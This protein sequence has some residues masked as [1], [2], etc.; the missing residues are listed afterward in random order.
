MNP[1]FRSRF[2]EDARAQAAFETCARRVFG[3]D[4]TRWKQKGLWDPQ[5]TP[6]AAFVDGKCVA[7]L[8]VYPSATLVG[9]QERQG[10]QL[11]TV[12]TLPEFRR[13]GLQRELWTR[14]SD[15]KSPLRG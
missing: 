13:R 9:G 2:F 5:Y 1:E 12:G 15:W 7:S 3:L 8:C 6:F 11:L 10:A 14:A 4:F